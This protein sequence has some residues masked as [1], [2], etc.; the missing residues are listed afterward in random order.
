M[1]LDASLGSEF[2]ASFQNKSPVGFLF[3]SERFAYD[4]LK[5]E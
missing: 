5:I 3:S 2:F 1:H 4:V